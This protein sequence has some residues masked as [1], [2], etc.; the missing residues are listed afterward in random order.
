MFGVLVRYV[1]YNWSVTQHLTAEQQLDAGIRYFDLRV[2]RHKASGNLLFSH[3]LYGADVI[4]CLEAIKKFLDEHKKEVVI[5]DFNHLY[6]M[7]FVHHISFIT[8]IKNIFGNK[9]N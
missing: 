8:N 3:G 9:I 7:E 2:S 6:E 5:L 4:S 1:I